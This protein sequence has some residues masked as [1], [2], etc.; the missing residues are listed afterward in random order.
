MGH[1]VLCTEEIMSVIISAIPNEESN[2]Y[3][4][5]WINPCQIYEQNNLNFDPSVII[6]LQA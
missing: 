6:K 4:V 1:P 5:V 2:K 3:L